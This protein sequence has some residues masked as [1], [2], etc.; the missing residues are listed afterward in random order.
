MKFDFREKSNVFQLIKDIMQKQV[1]NKTHLIKGR[2][3]NTATSKMKLI[4]TNS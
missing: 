2:S 1:L 3:R 4:M